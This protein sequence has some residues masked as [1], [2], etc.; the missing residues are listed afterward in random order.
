MTATPV[1][2]SIGGTTGVTFSVA[3]AGS[4]INLSITLPGAGAA[5]M[6]YNIKRV[7]N[8]PISI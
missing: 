1:L 2:V 8:T 6:T 5:Q 7:M 4:D 3:L